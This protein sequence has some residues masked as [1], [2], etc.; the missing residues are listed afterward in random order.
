MLSLPDRQRHSLTPAGTA[1][2]S[3]ESLNTS[4][5]L[6]NLTDCTGLEMK[7]LHAAVNDAGWQAEHEAGSE[8]FIQ[9]T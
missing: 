8:S 5:S 9:Q 1:V 3:S 7:G 2:P 4:F 6:A